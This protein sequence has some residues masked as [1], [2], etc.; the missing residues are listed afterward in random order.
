MNA[1]GKGLVIGL[2]KFPKNYSRGSSVPALSKW[3]FEVLE[4]SFSENNSIYLYRI[5]SS[6]SQAIL[7]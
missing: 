2:V 1:E 6:S 7:A 3:A 5:D 4:I